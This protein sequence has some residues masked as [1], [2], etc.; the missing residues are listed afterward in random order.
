ME[1]STNAKV[2][3]CR[4]L[5]IEWGIE[6]RAIREHNGCH[7]ISNRFIQVQITSENISDNYVI[8]FKALEHW[9]GPYSRKP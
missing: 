4:A 9:K 5:Q 3:A 7:I 2:Q 6:A 8:T 1:W